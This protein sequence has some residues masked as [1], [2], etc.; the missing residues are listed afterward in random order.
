MF[1]DIGERLLKNPVNYDLA[2]MREE[3]IDV[4]SIHGD[5]NVKIFLKSFDQPLKGGRQAE[6]VQSGRPQV[7]R[8]P[9]D[10]FN[11]LINGVHL[12]FILT[13][14]VLG[15]PFLGQA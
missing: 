4:W 12:L 15:Q 6:I 13:L 9:A 11:D 10:I 7:S 3:W 5:L 2:I 1:P 14:K 8:K